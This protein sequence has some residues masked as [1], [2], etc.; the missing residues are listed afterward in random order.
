M[1]GRSYKIVPVRF[2]KGAKSIFGS[3][4]ALGFNAL[5]TLLLSVVQEPTPHRSKSCHF[6]FNNAFPLEWMRRGIHH[7]STGTGKVFTIDEGRN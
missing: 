6:M 5:F 1:V 2:S 4:T 7:V 3:E